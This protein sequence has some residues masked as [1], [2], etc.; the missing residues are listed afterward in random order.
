M[1]G[2]H[3]AAPDFDRLTPGM[4]GS[5]Q[6]DRAAPSAKPPCTAALQHRAEVPLTEPCV[7]SCSLRDVAIAIRQMPGLFAPPRPARPAL[8]A[9]RG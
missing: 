6:S 7:M 9:R 3:R 8:T 5:C 2:I 4:L 1:L